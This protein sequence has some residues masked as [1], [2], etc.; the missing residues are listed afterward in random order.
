[1]QNSKPSK[2]LSCTKIVVTSA[3]KSD[4]QSH[5]FAVQ[6]EVKKNSIENILT[7][8]YEADFVERQLQNCNL[9]KI[10]LDYHQLSKNDRT[11][12]DLMESEAAMVDRYYELPSL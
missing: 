1:M 7:K 12:I 5:Y 9:S 2:D 8:I 6:T 11:F 10:N 3:G 4:V